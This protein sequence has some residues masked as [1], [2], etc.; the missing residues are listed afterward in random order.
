M[1]IN[2][3]QSKRPGIAAPEALRWLPIIRER[4]L[5]KW[6]QGK[7]AKNG[8]LGQPERARIVSGR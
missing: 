2:Q 5:L 1:L 4:L 7:F 8:S 3:I 6:L